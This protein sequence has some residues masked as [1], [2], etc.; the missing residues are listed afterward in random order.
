MTLWKWKLFQVVFSGLDMK[1]AAP[2]SLLPGAVEEVP[3]AI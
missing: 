3:S 2:H 1:E